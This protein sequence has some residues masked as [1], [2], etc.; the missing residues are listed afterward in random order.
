MIGIAILGTGDIANTHIEAYQKLAPRC[1][2]RALVDVNGQK[3]EEKKKKYQLSCPV[4]TDYHDLLGR[5][6][7]QLVSICLPPA[8]HCQTAV[9][10]L[11]AGKHVLCEKPMAPTLKECD[12]MLSAA[13]KGG[14][15]LATIAQNRFKQDVMRTKELLDSGKLGKP[16]FAQANSLWWRGDHYYDLVW[17]GTWEREGGG[18]TFIHAVHHIDLFLWLMGGVESVQAM[19]ANQN[20]R[21]S[22]VEDVSISTIRFQSGAVGSLV[23]SLVH[24]GER[25]NIIIDAERASIE[26]PHRLAVSRQLE[27]G[28]PVDDD[29]ARDALEAAFQALPKLEYTEHCGQIENMLTAVETG[30]EPLV[31][32][33]DGRRTVEF[34]AGVYQSAFL[35]QTV[36]FPMTEADPFYTKD[37]ILKHAVR[38]HQK[39]KSVESFADIGISVGGTL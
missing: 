35:G 22:E 30:S 10:L 14:A 15:K 26:I 12:E 1:E 32:G 9:D 28:Y 37:G 20:H 7:I 34:I 23:S 24:H 13:Q 25:Q 33:E 4:Y 27:N 31:T 18:C 39:G 3:A 19:V 21:G 11:L 2:I 8:L 29:A 16:L 17:R 6:D 36:R 38:F 5:E